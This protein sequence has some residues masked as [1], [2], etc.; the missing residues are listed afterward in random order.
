MNYRLLAF[1]LTLFS[2]FLCKPLMAQDFR[3]LALFPGKAMIE[4]QGKRILLKE[5]E[6]KNGFK[7][8]STDPFEQ[9]AVIEINGHA[10]SYSLGQHIGGG[11]ATPAVREVRVISDRGSYHTDGQINNQ[12]VRFVVDTGATSVAMSEMTA[13]SLGINYV[14]QP[15]GMAQTAAGQ[16]RA[17]RVNLDSVSIGGISQQNITG[18]VVEGFD[19][20]L[21][22][23]GMSFLKQLEISHEDN[24]MVIRQKF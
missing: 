13:S 15:Q 22:L 8:V 18:M 24:L 17:W 12:N 5:G 2:I 16:T 20:E 14:D 19:R 21:V 10:D 6:S 11:Y 4:L 9:R 7:L 1:W 23:L 3:V